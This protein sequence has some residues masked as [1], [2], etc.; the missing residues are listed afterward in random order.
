MTI[1]VRV[2][3]I[4]SKVLDVRLYSNP[5]I[6]RDNPDGSKTYINNPDSSIDYIDIGDV[7]Y[8]N[9]KSTAN[10][11]QDGIEGYIKAGN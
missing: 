6:I 2:S 11:R 7:R 5:D 1:K 4:E 9:I 10:I 3:P 8:H